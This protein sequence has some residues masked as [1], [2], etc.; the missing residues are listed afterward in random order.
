VAPELLLQDLHDLEVSYVVFIVHIRAG[1]LN[2]TFGLQG[3]V[4]ELLF[5]IIALLIDRF[6]GNSGLRRINFLLFASNPNI[7]NF[8][9]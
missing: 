7:N 8:V 5:T 4:T 1:T 9:N 3:Y 6:L 2:P